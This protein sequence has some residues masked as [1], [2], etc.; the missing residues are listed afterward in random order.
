[1]PTY[2]MPQQCSDVSLATRRTCLVSRCRVDWM[3]SY[4][5]MVC[6]AGN[7]IWWTWEVED[8]FK[9]VAKGNKQGMKDYAKKLHG[10]IDELAVT[11]SAWRVGAG[12]RGGG[13]VG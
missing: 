10:Q 3:M 12:G 8:V 9:K 1:M 6:L 13:G 7:Q 2:S 4:I 11:V 5:G